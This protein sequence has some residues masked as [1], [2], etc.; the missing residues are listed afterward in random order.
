M[1]R[2]DEEC[3]ICRTPPDQW[4]YV[5]EIRRFQP[6]CGHPGTDHTKSLGATRACQLTD[7]LAHP[8][9]PFW[10]SHERIAFSGPNKSLAWK[11]KLADRPSGT[12]C[13]IRNPEE[14]GKWMVFE[15]IKDYTPPEPAECSVCD[16]K[17]ELLLL[18]CGHWA[19][20]LCMTHEALAQVSLVS[21]LNGVSIKTWLSN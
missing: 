2:E 18:P 9:S 17:K 16:S 8:P 7:L 4:V 20:E 21:R 5:P 19:C 15:P 14:P 11:R 6:L 10:H 13:S 3:P 12:H 1:P